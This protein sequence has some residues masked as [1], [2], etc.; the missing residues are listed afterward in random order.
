VWFP[1]GP[2]AP[3]W[4]HVLGESYVI[5]GFLVLAAFALLPRRLLRPGA[6]GPAAPDGLVP[7]DADALR[8]VPAGGRAS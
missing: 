3:W 8:P 2:G 6:P 7:P 4:T 1:A 5:V